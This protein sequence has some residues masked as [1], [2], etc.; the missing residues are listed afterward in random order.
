MIKADIRAEV[1]MLKATRRSII[2]YLKM[3]SLD[4][5][6]TIPSGYRNN[7]IW[8]AG[9]CVVT[10]QKL[11]YS[12]SKTKMHVNDDLLNRYKKGSE[13]YNAVSN[14]EVEDIIALL[15]TTPDFLVMD[16]EKEIFGEFEPYETSYGYPLSSTLDAIRFNNLHEAL[17]LGYMMSMAKIIAANR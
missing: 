8:N 6:N 12:L 9:H 5:V 13:P 1:N 2:K 15:E 14:G 4:E 7:L 10:Q 17:H 11:V 16:W 3:H